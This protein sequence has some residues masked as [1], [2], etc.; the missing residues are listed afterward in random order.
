[1]AG[2]VRTADRVVNEL[3]GWVR[4]VLTDEVVPFRIEFTYGIRPLELVKVHG[5]GAI[6]VH[7]GEIA[8]GG[9]MAV[10]HHHAAP[11]LAWV[12]GLRLVQEF[13]LR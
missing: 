1:M 4:S 2:K 11:V 9:S 3:G 7:G 10:E 12:S 5:F 8:D 13:R 6:H